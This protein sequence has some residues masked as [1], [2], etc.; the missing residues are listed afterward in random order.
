MKSTRRKVQPSTRIPML[1]LRML[2]SSSSSARTLS[3]SLTR[4]AKTQ[5]VL[6]SGSPTFYFPLASVPLKPP[7]ASSPPSISASFASTIWCCHSGEAEKET[8]SRSRPQNAKEIVLRGMMC[9]PRPCQ[10][11][12]GAFRSFR[13]WCGWSRCSRKEMQ[14]YGH[15]DRLQVHLKLIRVTECVQEA[16]CRVTLPIRAYVCRCCWEP[17]S[18]C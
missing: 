1:Q 3:H 11:F 14:S 15:C 18:A 7:R 4:R 16:P 6:A 12:C 9:S 13:R 2:R 8:R 10:C 17:P 5:H